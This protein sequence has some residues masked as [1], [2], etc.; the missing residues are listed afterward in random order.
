MGRLAILKDLCKNKGITI[1]KLEQ[2]LGLSQGSLGKFDTNVPKADKLYAISKY[3]DVPMEIFFDTPSGK[4]GARKIEEAIG[5]IERVK[6]AVGGEEGLKR[7]S[8]E[9]E[10]YETRQKSVHETADFLIKLSADEELYT[11]VEKVINGSQE[12][13]DRLIQMAKLMGI[14]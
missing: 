6:E 12:Q 1:N 3:F 4:N 11:L 13:R 9:I 10:E 8:D 2:E 14:E 5:S 7:L